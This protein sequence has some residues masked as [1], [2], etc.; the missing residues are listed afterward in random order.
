MNAPQE[1]TPRQAALIGMLGGFCLVL[2]KLMQ[3]QFYVDD[4]MSR[5]AVVAYLTY[6]GF[7]VFAAIAGVYFAE[8]NIKKN[9]FIAGLL[10][11]S[12]LL[13]FFSAP[14]FRI[15]GSIGE[16]PKM[17]PKISFMLIGSAH[18]QEASASSAAVS[19]LNPPTNLKVVEYIDR[20]DLQ[21]SYLDAFLQAMGKQTAPSRYLFV[22]GR[23][24]DK[25]KATATAESLNMF[26]TQW[27]TDDSDRLPPAHVVKFVGND[28]YF[29][30]VGALQLPDAVLGTKKLAKSIAV[31]S[32][33]GN[34]STKATAA[35]SLLIE[36]V[37]VD[38]R[39]LAKEKGKAWSTN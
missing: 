22:V 16:P 15:D 7:I 18:A 23:T 8:H 30:T 39:D 3:A 26:S 19:A 5:T 2:L 20:K 38:A 32:L 1:L 33:S 24:T 21:P 17:I 13:T 14:N 4:P 29:V 11:P 6:A 9:T 25:D 35:A 36:G 31:D 10:A 37:V 28:Q 12:I 34:A 27:K